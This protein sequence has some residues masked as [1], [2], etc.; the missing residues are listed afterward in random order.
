MSHR[1][2]SRRAYARTC[3]NCGKRRK[4]TDPSPPW[5]CPG[6]GRDLPPRDDG[7]ALRLRIAATL[8]PEEEAPD[9]LI[10]AGRAAVWIALAVW[11]LHFITLDPATNAIGRSFMHQINLPFH[12]A[13]HVL[14]RP[15]GRF[16]TIL[17]G[18]LFQVL[19]PLIVAAAFLVRLHPFG[20]AVGLWWAGQ[21]LM[22]VG[23]YIHDARRMSLPLI[24]G[25]TGQDRPW[26]HDWHNLLSRL[27]LLS[28]DQALAGVAHA[29]GAAF[30]LSGLGW[31][32]IALYR[33]WMA[34][35][36]GSARGPGR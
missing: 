6:C 7:G 9:G 2:D 25:G 10:L 26:L 29:L 22:D 31:G 18:S 11:G 28:W 4:A 20:V 3:T 19:V 13:G 15:L 14:F 17:G 24:G 23:P 8:L 16:M 1:P 30:L 34:M 35:R 5:M 12:E 32:A 21:S 27:D 36:E 33:S